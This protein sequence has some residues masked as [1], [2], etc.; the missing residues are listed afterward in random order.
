MTAGKIK[1]FPAWE[2]LVSDIPAGDGKIDKLFFYSV[3]SVVVKDFCCVLPTDI[4]EILSAVPRL[5]KN[6]NKSSRA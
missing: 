1:L 3:A 2:S 4:Q 6:K 5:P